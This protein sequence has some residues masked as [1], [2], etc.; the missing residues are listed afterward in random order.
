MSHERF[1]CV[2]TDMRRLEPGP[3]QTRSQSGPARSASKFRFLLWKETRQNKDQLFWIQSAMLALQGD[4]CQP[5][6]QQ[7]EEFLDI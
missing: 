1:S 7:R 6:S 2:H 3:V 4:L 5:N